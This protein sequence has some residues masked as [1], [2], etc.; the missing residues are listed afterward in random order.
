MVRFTEPD[1]FLPIGGTIRHQFQYSKMLTEMGF[2]KEQIFLLNEGE[3]VWFLKNKAYKGEVIEGKN[4]YVDAYGVGDVGNI[5]LRDRKTL[6]SE[7]IVSVILVLDNQAR[8]LTRP[9]FVTRGFVFEKGEEK[10]FSDA[11]RIVEKTLNFKGG[12]VIDF[13]Q[14]RKEAVMILEDYFFKKRG[15]K[16]LVIVDII[17][18]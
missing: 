1:Y 13:G 5:V 18:I 17:Q 9:K 8:L 2:K 4:I 10:L 11:T 16:P 14:V 6:A 12:S 15:R 3:T 7:G